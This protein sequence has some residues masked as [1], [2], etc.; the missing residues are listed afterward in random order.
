MHSLPRTTM[1]PSTRLNYRPSTPLNE[2][3]PGEAD[4]RKRTRFFDVW[5]ARPKAES[6]RAFCDRTKYKRST[7]QDWLN[8]RD[9]LG[10]VAYRHTRQLSDR[11]GRPSR[12]QK[13]HVK[14][15]LDPRKNEVRD[16]PL[17]VQIA[18]HDLR[19]SVRQLRRRLQALTNK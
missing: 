12:I 13:N 1:A 5:D 2:T 15:L 7:I 10:D 14:R 18:V 8:Q 11:L 4:T 9:Q 16:E 6:Q 3:G 17:E 19:I